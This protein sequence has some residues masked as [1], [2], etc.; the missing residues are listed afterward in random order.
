M[1]EPAGLAASI[2]C[3]FQARQDMKLK[4]TVSARPSDPGLRTVG[5][6]SFAW[7]VKIAAPTGS[8]SKFDGFTISRGAVSAHSSR[9]RCTKTLGT[10]C[11]G[12]SIALGS[13][14]EVYVKS[15]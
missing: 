14:V 9:E 7:H 2:C 3:A 12:R 10:Q 11:I 4:R 6:P 15:S 13:D 1:L 5:R 8:C